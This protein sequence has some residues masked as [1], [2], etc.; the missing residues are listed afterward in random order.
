[1]VD[2]LEKAIKKKRK[3]QDE[4]ESM[5]IGISEDLLDNICMK[6]KKV[7]IYI[8]CSRTQMLTLLNYADKKNYS[9]NLLSWHKT[10]PIPTCNNKYLNDTEYIVFMREKGVQVYGSYHTKKTY[11]TTAVNK[12]EKQ[13]FKH[14]TVKP[15]DII[16]NLIINS[17]KENNTILDCFMGSGTTGV[18]CVNLN[19]NFIGIE[20]NEKY[21]NIA[22]D[23]IDI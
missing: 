12:K 16:E 19:R 6:M 8:F 20:L 14:P 17:S 4:I 2:F 10:N 11:F 13:E 9:W 5:M 18:A 21:F 23:R 15:L 3:Y 22:K 1:M 7:N